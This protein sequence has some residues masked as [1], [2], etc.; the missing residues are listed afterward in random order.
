MLS[1]S[2]VDDVGAHP[3]LPMSVGVL[4]FA[5]SILVLCLLQMQHVGSTWELMSPGE[6]L[7]QLQREGDG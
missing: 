6:A 4:H 5:G 7:N 2:V 3:T 1:V